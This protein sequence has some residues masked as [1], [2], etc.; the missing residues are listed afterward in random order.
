MGDVAVAGGCSCRGGGGGVV[1]WGGGGVLCCKK[2]SSIPT[3]Y[4][5][6]PDDMKTTH[7]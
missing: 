4:P 3:T 1:E 7:S 2:T 6:D 5:I